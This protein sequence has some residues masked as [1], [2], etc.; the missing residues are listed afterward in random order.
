MRSLRS[1]CLGAAGLPFE[2]HVRD[3]KNDHKHKERSE[4]GGEASH[5]NAFGSLFVVTSDPPRWNISHNN[6][7]SLMLR[8]TWFTDA[9]GECRA[10]GHCRGQSRGL[11]R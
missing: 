2:Q 11:L 9:R 5:L 1:S 4:F 3:R 10:R 7:L 6:T 8:I